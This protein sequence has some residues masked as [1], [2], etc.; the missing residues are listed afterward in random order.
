MRREKELKPPTKIKNWLVVEVLEDLPTGV[1]I[2]NHE[3][4]F[5]RNQ[6]QGYNLIFNGHMYKREANYRN[7]TNWICS[8]GNGKRVHE[9]KCIARAITKSDGGIK[10]GKNSHNHAPRFF[11]DKLNNYLLKKEIVCPHPF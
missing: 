3:Y 1:W 8:D 7:T 11:G 4:Y 6:K 2:E 9:N 5:V 10:L